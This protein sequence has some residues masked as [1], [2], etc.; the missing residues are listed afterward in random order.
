[1]D[2]L[3][4]CYQNK[5]EFLQSIDEG[6]VL[7]EESHA[8]D[9]KHEVKA[10][11]ELLRLNVWKVRACFDESGRARSF[12]APSMCV[13]LCAHAHARTSANLRTSCHSPPPSPL[14]AQIHLW[15]RGGDGTEMNDV[16]RVI[17]DT[18]MIIKALCKTI[19]DS[20]LKDEYQHERA[21]LYMVKLGRRGL[22][23]GSK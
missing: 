14:C 20:K 3:D 19:A 5:L 12:I 6:L 18:G 9:L 2:F 8:M 13:S 16:K 21:Q 10:R 23:K 11:F 17:N 1:M 7:F 4:R 22:G 15:A